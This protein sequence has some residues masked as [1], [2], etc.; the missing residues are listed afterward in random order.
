MVYED[1]SGQFSSK[2]LDS[3]D[4]IYKNLDWGQKAIW[5]RNSYADKYFFSKSAIPIRENQITFSNHYLLL[6]YANYGVS[7]NFTIAGGITPFPAL[8][9]ISPKAHLKLGNR[10]H[11]S[12]AGAYVGNGA[13]NFFSG[14]FNVTYGNAQNNIT[15]GVSNIWS[16]DV[17]FSFFMISAQGRISKNFSFVTENSFLPL[18]S[19]F[20]VPVRSLGFRYLNT[21]F[22]IELGGMYLGGNVTPDNEYII[23]PVI[24]F[25][26]ALNN[27]L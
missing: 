12:L 7:K 20:V 4:I 3:I 26:Y 24:G 18:A 11:T 16:G 23:F 19:F 2:S 9:Y 27:F 6:N 5:F 8:L 25:N 10:V 22:S 13:N 21:S 14:K 17:S 15:I 1:S